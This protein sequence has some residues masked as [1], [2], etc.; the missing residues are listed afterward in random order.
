MF[1]FYCLTTLPAWMT[2]FSR[3]SSLYSLSTDCTENIVFMVPLLLDVYSVPQKHVYRAPLHINGRLFL[4]NCSCFSSVKSEYFSVNFVAGNCNCVHTDSIELRRVTVSEKS[5]I[6]GSFTFQRL[7][8]K[9]SASRS[10]FPRMQ[11]IVTLFSAKSDHS[12]AS[13]FFCAQYV[14][15][16]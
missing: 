5:R 12:I 10:H 8:P 1:I 3:W 11:F 4:L 2:N 14:V 13:P 6:K 15:R 7:K 9:A 16:N